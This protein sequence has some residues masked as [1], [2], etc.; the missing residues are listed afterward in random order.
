MSWGRMDGQQL[1]NAAGR[2]TSPEIVGERS[3]PIISV[4]LLLEVLGEHFC[5]FFALPFP[6]CARLSINIFS[7]KFDVCKYF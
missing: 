6:L 7:I 4:H 1:D 3:L 2:V 5:K